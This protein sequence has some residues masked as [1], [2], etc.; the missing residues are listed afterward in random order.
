[1]VCLSG[2]IAL[3]FSGSLFCANGAINYPGPRGCLRR[4]LSWILAGEGEGMGAG[5]ADHASR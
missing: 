5:V 2:G 1:M 3:K 4:A